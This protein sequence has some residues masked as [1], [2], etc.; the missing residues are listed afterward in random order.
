MIAFEGLVLARGAFRLAASGEIPAGA[1]TALIGP[2]GGG[3]SSL[4]AAIGGFLAPLSGRIRIGGADMA[5]VPPARRPVATVFQDHNLFP[6]LSAA[7]NVGLG[8]RPDLRLSAEERARV[9]A[10]LDRT[11]LQ[12]FGPRRPASLSGG[13]RSRVALA[14]VLLQRRPVLLLDEPFAA[15]GPG[16]RAAMLDLVAA[17]AAEHALTVLMVTH[18]PGDARRI[19]SHGAYLGE[20]AMTPPVPLAAFFAD[21]APGLRAYLGT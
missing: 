20:G 12:G 8:L 16:Q 18:D 14:R 19:A 13:E 2:S 9:E 5:G 17:L 3:K 4:L 1:V 10:A 11:G 6:H 7:E 15:L 21:P